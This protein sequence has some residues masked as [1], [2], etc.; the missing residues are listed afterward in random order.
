MKR[1]VLTLAV[2]GSLALA[3]CKNPQAVV[4]KRAWED[5]RGPYLGYVQADAALTEAEKALRAQHVALMDL[6][7]KDMTHE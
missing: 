6:T 5:I 2:V 7:L 1:F 3:G 4:L